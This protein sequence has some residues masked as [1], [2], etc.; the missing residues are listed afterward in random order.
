[1]QP[2]EGH[3]SSSKDPK[4]KTIS[5]IPTV[6]VQPPT[7]IQEASPAIN[8]FSPWEDEPLEPNSH[9]ESSTAASMS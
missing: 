2:L 6:S 9:K 7:P 3:H 4:E 5:T 8:R 1:M